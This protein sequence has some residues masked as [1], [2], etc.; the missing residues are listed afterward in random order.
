MDKIETTASQ[1]ISTSSKTLQP[2]L[3]N[4]FFVLVVAWIAIINVIHNFGD[5]SPKVQS[6][7]LSKPVQ[8]LAVFGTIY[9]T[10]GNIKSSALWT[11]ILA[12]VYYLITMIKE[13]FDIITN[14]PAV[15]PGCQNATVKDLLALF[16]G[17][18]NKLTSAMASLGVPLNVS[19]TDANAPLIATM[20]VNHG[21]KITEECRQPM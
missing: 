19:L 18:I 4:K 15:Y 5:L 16:D 7:V 13:N 21:K 10:I 14:T 8:V 20:L 3:D 6:F 9:Y 11:M 12:I 2:I 17:D 1:I